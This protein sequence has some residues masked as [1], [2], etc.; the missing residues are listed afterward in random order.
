MVFQCIKIYIARE[1]YDEML[2]MEGKRIVVTGG[3]SGIGE[4]LV[5]QSW[6]RGAEVFFSYNTNEKRAG[7]IADETGARATNLLLGNWESEEDFTNYIQGQ[8]RDVHYFILNA[9][10]EFSGGL[11]KH[12][13]REID[14]ILRTNLN[15]NLHLLR[16]FITRD[17]MAR[18]GQISVIGSIAAD[19]NQEQF[20]YSA[21]KAGLRGAVN[22]L[23]YDRDVRRGNIGVKLIELAF[24]RTPQTEEY[25]GTLERL[26]KRRRGDDS[27]RE[28]VERGLV[29]DADYA[30][31]EI[32]RW[33]LDSAVVGIRSLPEGINLHDDI[34]GKYY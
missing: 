21:A 14:E 7:E 4:E 1:E 5:G 33:T 34:R 12:G 32:L 26:V 30:A 11:G 17:L 6:E 27:W 20:A 31:R 15:G 18:G 9:G 24:V 2:D 8:G 28:F 19:G 25:L 3:S 23:Q 13:K 29:M 22:S 16:D 10:K